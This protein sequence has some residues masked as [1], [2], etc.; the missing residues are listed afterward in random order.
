MPLLLSQVQ[1][2]KMD[3]VDGEKGLIYMA[4][5]AEA[6]TRRESNE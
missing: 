5:K 3:G 2:R 6:R 1:K 4:G